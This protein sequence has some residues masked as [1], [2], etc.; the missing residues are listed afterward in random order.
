MSRLRAL[1]A[2]VTF[3]VVLLLA[4]LASAQSLAPVSGTLVS[5]STSNPAV[6]AF[7]MGRYTQALVVVTVD[8]GGAHTVTIS[9]RTCKDC[10]WVTETSATSTV[11]PGTPLQ[12]RV[13]LPYESIRVSVANAGGDVVDVKYS[14]FQL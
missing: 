4:F 8:D 11:S 5:A 12:I 10:P 6:G 7:A 3:I 14:L 13:A 1:A 2:R 9:T